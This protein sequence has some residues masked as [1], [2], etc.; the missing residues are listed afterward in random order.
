[1]NDLLLFSVAFLQTTVLFFMMKLLEFNNFCQK[2]PKSVAKIELC[3][4][5]N[6]KREGIGAMAG[7]LY[8]AHPTTARWR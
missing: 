5:R 3:Q 6:F 7:H 2:M 8:L 1:V 4:I